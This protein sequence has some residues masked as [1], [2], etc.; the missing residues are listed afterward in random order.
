MTLS[1]GLLQYR[2]KNIIKC[3]AAGLHLIRSELHFDNECE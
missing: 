2:S 1:W 3:N